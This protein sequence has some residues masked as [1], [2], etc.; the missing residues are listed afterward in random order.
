[1]NIGC[2][3]ISW[4]LVGDQAHAYGEVARLGFHGFETPGT[5]IRAWNERPGGWRALVNRFGIPTV[6]AY[7]SHDYRPASI[8]ADEQE[9]RRDADALREVGGSVLI[10]ASNNRPAAPEQTDLDR[11]AG[12]MNRVGAHCR[13]IGLSAGVHPH[14]DSLIE[15]DAEIEGLMARLDPALVGF[16]PDSGQIAK[17]GGDALAMMRRYRDRTVHVHLKDWNGISRPDDTNGRRNYEPLGRGILPLAE[18]LDL[19]T[20]LAGFV[21]VELDVTDVVPEPDPTG[22][23]VICR[24]TLTALLGDRVAWRSPRLGAI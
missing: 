3:G 8:A 18:M 23:I 4:N 20:D 21:N 9:A 7:S 24:E 14:T 2:V 19:Y 11:I 1:M 13:S 6:A 10:L 12:C 17:G 16:V 15:T 5:T 22:L